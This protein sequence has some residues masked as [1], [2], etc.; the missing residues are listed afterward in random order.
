VNR[1]ATGLAGYRRG[2]A[3]ERLAAW[4]LRFKGW[5][6]VA[7][8]VR[9]PRGSGAG[10]IDLV[11][12]RRKVLAFVEIKAR[13]SAAEGLFAIDPRQRRRLLRAAEWF[14]KCHPEYSGHDLRFDAVVVSPGR[15][16]RHLPDAWR[17][18]T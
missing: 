6:I 12:R 15:W 11:A 16:P 8:R 3:A 4:A 10:E 2:L 18:E 17:A 13:P 9:P 5:R 1:A 7:R 14:I